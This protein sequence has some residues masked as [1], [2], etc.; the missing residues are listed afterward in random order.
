MNPSIITH[1]APPDPGATPLN[2]VQLVTLLNALVSSEFREPDSYIPYV[3]QSGT[4][5]VEDQDKSWLELDSQ[6]RPIAIKIFW[7]GHWRRVYNGMLGE[8]RNYSGDPTTDFDTDGLGKVGLAYDG[9]HLCN[10]KNGVV[11][12]SDRFIIGAHMNGSNGVNGYQHGQWVT[13]AIDGAG[14]HSGGVRDITLTNNNTYQ[15]TSNIGKTLVGK[16]NVNGAALEN[17]GI[18]WGLPSV[19]DEN[20]NKNLIASSDGNTNPDNI[21]VIPPYLAFAFIIFVGYQS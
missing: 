16:Y 21:Q 13:T 19:Q 2:L 10:G 11:D 17:S 4:P 3:I 14:N 15:P 12:L 8:I 18:L 7:H 5:G 1:F 9:W 20:K 6:G